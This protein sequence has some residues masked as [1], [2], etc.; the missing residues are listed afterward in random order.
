MAE[1]QARDSRFDY[2]T[3]SNLVL[4][5]DNTLVDKR[6]R[7]EATGEVHSLVNTINTMRMGDR[8][9]RSKVA[10]A[11]ASSADMKQKHAKAMSYYKKQAEQKRST[12][13]GAYQPKSTETR[14]TYDG[15]L[16]YI[17]LAIGDQPAE[18]LVGA[19]EEVL[20]TLKNQKLHDK[21]RRLEIEDLLGKMDDARY[22]A[23]VNLARRLTDFT[24]HN[25]DEAKDFRAKVK[26]IED[27][28][29]GV[30]VEF[31]DEED[32]DMVGEGIESGIT[33]VVQEE[34]VDDDDM[35][36][37]GKLE[38]TLKKEDDEGEKKLDP[39]DIDA[40]WIQREVSKF[41]SDPHLSQT[42]CEKI[43]SVLEEE[44]GNPA[45]IE[46]R[47]MDIIQYANF[48][49][50]RLVRDNANVVLYC[51]KL[52]RAKEEEKELLKSMMK[53]NP[54][55]ALI[56]KKLESTDAHL[57]EEKV[58]EKSESK[59]KDKSEKVLQ[60]RQNMINLDEMAFE[61]GSHLMANKRCTLPDGS[62]RETQR[63]YEIV[64]VPPKQA[65]PPDANELIPIG[66]LPNYCK[67]AFDGY[68]KLNRIQSAICDTAL[69]TDENMLICAPTGAGKTNVA[70]LSM[71]REIGKHINLDG[72]INK[73]DFKIIYISPMRSLVQ[74]Q[75]GSFS[76]RLESY[77]IKVGELTGDNQM[78]REEIE[79]TQLI[80]CTPEKWDIVT[81]KGAERSYTNLVR[82]III[83]EVHLLHDDRGPVLEAIVA[84]TLR[85]IH[86]FGAEQ[87]RIV[88]LSATLPNYEDVASFLHVDHKKGLFHFGNEFRPV[89]L[90]TNFIGVTEKKAL[91]R[92]AVMN[93]CVYENVIKNAG[94]NQILIFVHSRKETGKTARALRDM[95]LDRDTLGMFLKEGSAS[96]EILR[97]ESAECQDNDLKE[98]LPY[99]F[100]I[101]HAGM[102]RVDRTLVEDLFADGH[103]QVLVSTATLAWGVNLPAHSVI[104]KGTKVYSPDKGRWMELSALD[105][106]QMLGRAGRPQYDTMG[107]GTLITDHAE[108]Q[109]YL[110]LMHEQLPIESQM[111]AKLPDLLCAEVV[112]GNVSSVKVS[113]EHQ[114]ID[115]FSKTISEI[116]SRIYRV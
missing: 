94:Q 81:R 39:R 88:G 60:K 86:S 116:C 92:F 65:T 36:I 6:D 99:G 95:C 61:A 41:T 83:D 104:I 12:Y 69:K 89:P 21:K 20:L 102:S 37:G 3:N 48:E 30:N 103:V 108:L 8:V 74:E 58:E 91:K 112:L 110:S 111:I 56:L 14:E 16:S 98:V 77:G 57:D 59:N 100:A 113:L 82:L 67:G 23:L 45:T 76:K 90:E 105:V 9:Q 13:A 42:R 109:Y 32:E 54:E 22:Q 66:D 47:M 72:S 33:G 63:G 11:V 5:C 71:L 44:Q 62:V 93:E 35:V 43:L 24:L 7:N 70:L 25:E 27:E 68:E 29:F 17:S 107:E 15:F 46:N 2:K 87:C 18:V 49:F 85:G 4:R 73:D 84:R 55:L 28:K 79:A 26:D 101:H 40:Y 64:R 80:I 53:K 19:A 96:T 97:A 34:E 31:E 38:T 52:A 75:V 78:C 50:V 51:T 1:E 115:R 106:L 10:I 114:F